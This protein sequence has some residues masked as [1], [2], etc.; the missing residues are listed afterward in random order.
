LHDQRPAAFTPSG[1]N[2]TLLEQ[3][4]VLGWNRFAN[5]F[6]KEAWTETEQTPDFP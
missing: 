2:K 4:E 5:G 1:A 3:S 6:L